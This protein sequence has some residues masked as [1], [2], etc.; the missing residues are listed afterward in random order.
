MARR[1]TGGLYRHPRT[2]IYWVRFRCAGVE[3]RRSTGTRDA[4]RAATKGRAL[5][6]AIEGV[7]RPRH[8]AASLETLATN[9]QIAKR[10][11]GHSAIHLRT[12]ASRWSAVLAVAGPDT[13][14]S[15]LDPIAYASERRAQGVTGQTIRRELGLLKRALAT[16]GIAKSWPRIA[17]D[18]PDECRAGKLWSDSEIAAWLEELDGEAWREA[19]VAAGTGLRAHEL[20]RIRWEHIRGDLLY[21]PGDA[22]KTGPRTIA[23]SP[24]V[25]SAMGDPG[26]GPVFSGRSHRRARA[27]AARRAGLPRAPTLRDLR[28]S[29]ATRALER[30]QDPVALMRALGHKDLAMTE[31]YLSSTEQRAR[32]IAQA[33]SPAGITLREVEKV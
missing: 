9:D 2:G 12:L 5:R 32:S 18:P 8:A 19:I 27:S 22:S 17:S 16:V 6:S 11:E 24:L 15:D 3:Y 4:R 13:D 31:R 26:C 23:L 25:R 14:A 7:E 20:A 10:S 29:F 21:L 33:G 1:S 28:H 30:C